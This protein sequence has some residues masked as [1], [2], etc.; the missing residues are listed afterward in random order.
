MWEGYV[1]KYRLRGKVLS[2]SRALSELSDLRRYRLVIIDES[3]N[4]RN[5]EGKRYRAIQEYIKDNESK[6]ILLS[7][8]PYNKTYLDLSAQLRLFVSEELDLGI[9]PER[10]IR[11]IGEMEFIRRHQAPIRSIAAFEKSEYTDDWRDLM[12]L[13]M[14]RRTRSFIKDNYAFTDE[15]NKRKYL[16]FADGTKSYF[17]DRVPKA[18]QFKFDEKNPSDQYARLYSDRVVNIVNGLSLPRYGLGNYLL[19]EAEKNA[20]PDEK[21]Q[22]DNLSRAG[23]RLMGFCRTNLFKRLESSGESFLLSVD[24]HILRNYVYIHAIENNLP[25]PI[26][27]QSTELFDLGAND[28]DVDSSQPGQVKLEFED[29]NDDEK[30]VKNGSEQVHDFNE[31]WYKNRAVQLY[32]L[33]RTQ[34]S[35]KFKWIKP[36]FFD[37]HLGK[38]LLSDSRSLLQIMQEFGHWDAKA[39]TKLTALFEELTNKHPI[40]KVL[41]FTQFA[42]TVR[43]LKKELDKKGVKQLEDV[44]GQSEDPTDTAWR[45]S[46]TTNQVQKQGM[47]NPSEVI[48][49]LISTDVL[50]EGQN[51]QDCAIVIN[52]DL[53]WALVRLIQRI[54]RVDRIGQQSEKIYCYSALPADGLER[55]IHLRAKVRQRLSENGEVVGS[56][57]IYFEDDLS[58]GKLKDLYTEK[59]GILEGEADNEVDLA[60]FAYQIWR[61]AIKQD[62]SLERKIA[63]LPDVVY[64]T[65]NYVP[66]E[67][68]PAGV[69]V[70]AKT[71]EGNDSLVWMNTKGES[72]TQSQLSI[73]KAADCPP[74]TPAIPK[75]PRHHDLVRQGVKHIVQQEKTSGGQLGRPSGARYRTYDRLKR[76]YDD[77]KKNQPLFARDELERAIDDIYRFP[78]RSSATDILNRQLRTGVSDDNLAELVIDLRSEDRLS[79]R[80]EEIEQQEPRIICSLGLFQKE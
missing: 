22:M 79:I 32:E 19:P 47:P 38:L 75:D 56:D 31:S 48:R 34:E 74:E 53:P 36:A 24:R 14:V 3:Q 68:E 17:P 65:K 73:L 30:V 77:L 78:L 70:Y 12:R 42:D 58:K 8:T 5:R 11:E 26:G 23:K 18:L 1:H 64:S 6:V 52:Y 2:S 27:L 40:E 13:Y 21:R 16:L 37:S 35:K 28:E 10:L 76:Y 33:Y 49:V 57:E 25:I 71:A 29:D 45:F 67:K 72:V 55:I 61:N 7:A 59:S 43:Y 80:E 41:I 4:L 46:P 44:T 9:K 66:T 60:S 15:T 50:S 69:L 63:E 54:G 20:T 51:L 39:D 62:P